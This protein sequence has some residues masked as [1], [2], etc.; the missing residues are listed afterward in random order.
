MKGFVGTWLLLLIASCVEQD[1]EQ[2]ELDASTAPPDADMDGH[3][4]L[5]AG[6]DDCDDSDATRYPGAPEVPYDDIDQDCD[7]SDLRDVDADGHDALEAGGDDCDDGDAAIYPGAAD[8][9]GDDIDQS[10]DGV[11]GIDA[12]GDGFP[13]AEGGGEDCDDLDPA[14]HPDATEIWYDG[15]DADCDGR[16]DYDQDG[17]HYVLS[18]AVFADGDPCDGYPGPGAYAEEDC[19]DT[20]PSAARAT[21]IENSPEDA[22][23]GV[24]LGR[25]VHVVVSELRTYDTLVTVT[26]ASGQA[27]AG[28]LEALFWFG[29]TDYTFTPDAAFEYAE[30]YTVEVSHEC[31]TDVFSF[32]TE[33][34]I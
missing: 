24:A 14:I 11:D 16:C 9:V 19:D 13:S 34:G 29:L 8:E 1:P 22:E 4:A 28:T 5:A 7:G 18:G 31:G 33:D 25:T 3:D 2:G 30:T 20:D 12:D 10:C 27:V 23:I 21:L 17:D 6:G 32:T 26:D 15:I